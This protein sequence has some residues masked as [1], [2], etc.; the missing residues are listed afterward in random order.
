M[1][2]ITNITYAT[3]TALLIAVI[4]AGCIKNDIPYPR[5][6]P[7]ITSLEVR[8]QSQAA[9]LDTINRIAT[10]YLDETA[11]IYN[12]DILQCTL[13]DK[14]S[15]VGDSIAGSIDLSQPRYYILQIYQEYVWTLKAVQNITRNFSVANQIGASV[16]D[17][18]GRRI[19][20]TLPS[21]ADI[22][23][24]KVL[25][26]K[27]GSE[28]ST[29]TPEI[30]GRYIDLTRPYQITVTDYGR[31]ADWTIYCLTTEATVTTVRADAWTNVAWVY[32]EAQEGR[33]NYIEYRAASDTEW[34]RVPDSWLTVDGGSFHARIIHLQ[35]LT[36][37][38]ARAV[39]GDEY[40]A[41]IE[42]RTGA[43]IQPPNADF[44]NWW[45]NGKVWNPWADGGEQFWDT[46]NKGATTLGSSNTQP[47]DDTPTGTGRSARLETRFVGIGM[48]GKLA[49][50]NIFAG[51]YV[52]TDGT[53][54]VL[55]FGKPFAERPT[56]LRGY[57]TYHSA[58]I[59]SVTS[60]FND[61]KNRPDTCTVWAALIDSP[62]PFEIRTNPANRQLFDP[63]APYVIA[64]GAF[65]SG[66]DCAQW[67]QFEF[68][69]QYKATDRVPRYILIV[70]SASKYGDYFTGGNGSVLCLDDLQL[71]Y[72]Y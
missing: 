20:V 23:Q 7:N 57:Y 41:E 43:V 18:P 65:Q 71:L 54:G 52:R 5:I 62:E 46:G 37:Y 26:A 2:K 11:D 36:D 25:T 24:V 30:E 60:G 55:S 50:G 63:E 39:S 10:V 9:Q 13:S 45:L 3:L 64:Y 12:V 27:L 42:F 68:N 14:A 58:P 6:Q 22:S 47:S 19:V 21:T 32:G 17:V 51:E 56:R 16:I 61:L 69:L 1:T 72:D 53:N 70:G 59:S 48:V 29:I 34:I 28:N 15:F 38:V 33:D 66:D 44:D 4:A 49:A 35:A 31:S 40:G 8:H 67:S